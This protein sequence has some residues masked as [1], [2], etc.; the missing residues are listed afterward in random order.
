MSINHKVIKWLFCCS[1]VQKKLKQLSLV[2]IS[3]TPSLSD[4]LIRSLKSVSILK[5]DMVIK[6]TAIRVLLDVSCKRLSNYH[7][8]GGASKFLKFHQRSSLIKR[9]HAVIVSNKH[10]VTLKVLKAPVAVLNL[11]KLDDCLRY[12][13]WSPELISLRIFI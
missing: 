7:P 11:C 6:S 10:C 5:S 12:I 1:S 4:R 3:H 13:V 9:F 8:I 2:I